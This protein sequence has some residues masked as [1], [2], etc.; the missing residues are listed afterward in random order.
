MRLLALALMGMLV[1]SCGDCAVDCAP[2]YEV[3]PGACDCRPIPYSGG[4]AGNP[5]GA[6]LSSGPCLYGLTCIEGCPSSRLGRLDIPAGVCSIGGRDT[7][8]CGAVD[9]P[10]TTAGTTCLKPA[11]C[12]YHG[13]C[14]TAAERADICARPE[15]AHFD[16][17]GG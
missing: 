2:G 14:V 12:D 5:L 17:S 6:C 11:C 7:C 15:G 10:C 1:G 16:C 3:V 13:V 9:D 8:G 4:S